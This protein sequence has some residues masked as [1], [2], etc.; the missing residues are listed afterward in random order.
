[1][2]I[3]RKKIGL[4]CPS[5]CIPPQQKKNHHVSVMLLIAPTVA[6]VF[7][8]AQRTPRDVKLMRKTKMMQCASLGK[9]TCDCTYCV[10]GGSDSFLIQGGAQNVHCHFQGFA[11]AFNGVLLMRVLRYPVTH[12][13]IL[14][15]GFPSAKLCNVEQIMPNVMRVLFA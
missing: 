4:A 3:M 13:G 2:K 14:D 11:E 6:H 7:I 8:V 5:S 9:C 10:A 12:V 1:M 15:S